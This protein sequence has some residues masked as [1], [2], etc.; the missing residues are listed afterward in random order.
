MR[1][2][3]HQ[4]HLRSLRRFMDT[5]RIRLESSRWSGNSFGPG[6]DKA[7][8]LAVDRS[9]RVFSLSAPPTNESHLG[10]VRRSATNLLPL[11]VAS[12]ITSLALSAEAVT[13]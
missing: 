7:V 1:I 5:L 3:A 10:L 8:D 2:I 13:S 9:L 12:N 4:H 11:F 6:F